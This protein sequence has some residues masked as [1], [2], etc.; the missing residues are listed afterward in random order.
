MQNI[1][2]LLGL[3]NSPDADPTVDLS[4][5]KPEMYESAFNY[6]LPESEKISTIR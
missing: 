4:N 3:S 6:H 1:V 2:K 5:I